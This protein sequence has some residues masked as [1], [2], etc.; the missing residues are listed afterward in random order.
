MIFNTCTLEY[1][2]Y[3][4]GYI[5]LNIPA[6]KK[7]TTTDLMIELDDYLIEDGI[8]KNLES[9]ADRIKFEI[10]DKKIPPITLLLRCEET[11]KR[12][13][14]LPSMP[15]MK[16]DALFAKEKKAAKVNPNYA[17]ASN[18]FQHSLGFIY[19]TYFMPK[20]VVDAF[21]KLAKL[22]G[23]SIRV[24]E[25]FGFQLKRSLYYT[26]TYAYFYIFKSI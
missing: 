1:C 17:I 10:G 19:N 15:R 12:V 26:G 18:V 8:P 2:N 11:F 5:K 7:S 25:P 22:L 3:G 13:F 24:V 16:A 21:K 14:T 4:L 6:D 20:S 9:I 23:T